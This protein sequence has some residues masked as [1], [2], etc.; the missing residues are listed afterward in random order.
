MGDDFMKTV[1][2]NL[3]VDE[4]ENDSMQPPIGLVYIATYTFT[5]GYD[6]EVC[7]LSGNKNKDLH[8][9]IPKA[10][11]YGFSTYSV[12]YNKVLDL[13]K[14]IRM[15]NPGA[16][17]IAG[18]PHASA[19]PEI[20][21]EDFDCVIVGEGEK[22]FCSVLEHIKNNRKD[23]IP[24]IVK[25]EPIQDLDSLPFPDYYRFCDLKKYARS[26]QGMS[27]MTV[28][29]S[30]GCNFK[31]KFCNSTVVERGTWRARSAENVFKEIEWHHSKGWRAF[32]FNDDNFLVNQERA[33][34]ICELI[35][36]LN[37]AFR[38]FARA[39][40][41]NYTMCRKLKEAGCQNV[42]IGVE[43]LS[44]KMLSLMGKASTVAKIKSG[45]RIAKDVGIFTRG[46]FICGF[47]GE[48]EE[49]LY[50]SINSLADIDL[51]EAIV[52]PCIPYP[53]TPLFA[54]R[55]KYGITAIDDDY[56]KYLQVGINKKAGFVMTTKDFGPEKVDEWRNKYIQKFEQVGIKWAGHGNIK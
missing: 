50:E 18:G 12:T 38:I 29:T 15:I 33:L 41:L 28:D 32:R 19:L 25:A 53:G 35:T 24:A 17:L 44:P 47:P 31:C 2:I 13:V 56:S 43:S 1:L 34:K 8:S 21:K 16:Y 10:D 27:A 37:I 54:Q 40:S 51:D 22:V 39:E 7:D 30:R 42:S 5:N 23:L 52:Y 20:V 49:T 6:I 36:P 48:T 9:F 14:K 45:L 4:L 46:F 11:V 3:P 26:I 55:E